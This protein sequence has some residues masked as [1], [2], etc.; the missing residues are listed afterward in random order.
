MTMT[1]NFIKTGD[2][3]CVKSQQLSSV[4]ISDFNLKKTTLN[5]SAKNYKFNL[6]THFN[7]NLNL[8][9]TNKLTTTKVQKYNLN[10]K[11]LI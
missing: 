1:C 4:N 7:S 10:I 8:N 6:N 9:T 3:F 2:L 5:R 11:M